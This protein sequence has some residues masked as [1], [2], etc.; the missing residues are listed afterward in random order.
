MIQEIY[1]DMSTRRNQ[2]FFRFTNYHF[3]H[4]SKYIIF[5]GHNLQLFN[6]LYKLRVFS[7]YPMKD[8]LASF[9][10]FPFFR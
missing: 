1:I 5:S 8:L 4:I 6:L 9:L 10:I 2:L 3:W 7:Q